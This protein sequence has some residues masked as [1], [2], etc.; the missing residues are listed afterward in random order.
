MSEV[1]KFNIQNSRFKIWF[2]SNLVV[3]EFSKRV[4]F[5]DLTKIMH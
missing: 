1:R 4:I 3:E 2:I 5:N